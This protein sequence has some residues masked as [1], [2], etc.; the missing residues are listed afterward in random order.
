MGVA[1]DAAGVGVAAGTGATTSLPA[2]CWALESVVKTPHS[3]AAVIN[4]ESCFAN[5]IR[6][7]CSYFPVARYAVR[8]VRVP[9]A[10]ICCCKPVGLPA[11]AG[12]DRVETGS[13]WAWA[14]SA[15][16]M[17]A[18]AS[19]NPMRIS[20]ATRDSEARCVIRGGNLRDTPKRA[21][22]LRNQSKMPLLC[23]MCNSTP[24]DSLARM[25]YSELLA[26]CRVRPS[27]VAV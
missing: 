27:V 15:I 23:G 24:V 1:G 16:S 21:Y 2:V 14:F 3:R 9:A 22:D 26:Q 17:M 12:C 10:R 4:Q 11:R 25:R 20:A 13:D 5:V 6:S 19:N 18:R 7:P 8:S